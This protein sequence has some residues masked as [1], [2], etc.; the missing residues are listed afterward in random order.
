MSLGHNGSRRV[1][2][3]HTLNTLWHVITKKSHN[4]SSK[5][6]I[7]CWAAFTAILGCVQPSGHMWPRVAMNEAQHKI[8]NLLKTLWDFFV[9]TRCNV[10]NVWPKTT[11][12]LLVWPRDAKRLNTPG[13]YSSSISN[14]WGCSPSTKQ[15]SDTSWVSDLEI[16]KNHV[17]RLKLSLPIIYLTQIHWR[18]Y[19]NFTSQ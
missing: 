15:S 3:G 19:N 1:V 12:L 13:N 11:L 16:A 5:F 17:Q 2:L 7:L 14:V 18:N 6:M 8:V 10:F 4:V 9:I